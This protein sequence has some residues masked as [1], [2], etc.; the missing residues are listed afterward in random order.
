V[1]V[2]G[3]PSRPLVWREVVDALAR[4]FTVYAYDLLGFGERVESA[5]HGARR[6]VIPG[7]RHFSMLD[8][9]GPVAG[10]LAGFLGD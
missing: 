6:E 5:I 7:A 8:A 4:R 3:T 10:A 2:H 9:P 1:L